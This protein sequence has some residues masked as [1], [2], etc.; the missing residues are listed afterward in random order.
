M[1]FYDVIN[2]RK[3]TRE[4]QEKDV[5][6]EML[7]RLIDAGLAAPSNNH[8]REW[9]FVI[10]RTPEEKA[11]ALQ[12]VKEFV[13]NRGVT[14]Q[15]KRF[16]EG[17]PVQ[18]MYKYAMPR[19]YTM[20]ND[21]PYVILPFFKIAK[22]SASSVNELNAFASIW[23]VIENIFLAA[24]DEGLGTS[25][26]IPVGPESEKVCKAV[27]APE[28][29]VMPCYIGVGYPKEDAPQLEQIR[30]SAGEKMHFGRW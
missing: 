25:M 9:E 3:T 22:L 11:P 29:W 26:R 30:Y 1:E 14:E 20:L 5:P 16:A 18:R 6:M 17:S 24:A 10:L 2:K 19:Q 27:G 7:E 12:F 23:C 21:A 4:W 8:L 28:G 13:E 15:E